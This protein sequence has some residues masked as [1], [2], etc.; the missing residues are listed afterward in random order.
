MLLIHIQ[1]TSLA[2][3]GGESCV[4]RRFVTARKLNSL[5]SAHKRDNRR[6]V[7]RCTRQTAAILHSYSTLFLVWPQA[8]PISASRNSKPQPA[9]DPCANSF[10][11]L[12]LAHLWRIYTRR[13]YMQKRINIGGK[14]RP[15]NPSS[16]TLNK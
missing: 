6:I 11:S 12:F 3:L 9:D 16:S 1:T 10:F 14:R 13:P 15:R 2:L 7:W 5:Q 4:C 8:N